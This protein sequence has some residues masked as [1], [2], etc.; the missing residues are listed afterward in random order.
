METLYSPILKEEKL[1]MKPLYR[2]VLLTILCGLLVACSSAPAEEVGELP[3]VAVLS[4]EDNVAE[5]AVTE[6]IDLS[7]SNQDLPT[8]EPIADEPET[9]D[10]VVIE[11]TPEP[12][13][14]VA[15][16]EDNAGDAATDVTTLDID[17]TDPVTIA[18]EFT[19]TVTDRNGG[20]SF[21]A[22]IPQAEG[23][24]TDG[25]MLTNGDV[26]V[27]LSVLGGTGGEAPLTIMNTAYSGSAEVQSTFSLDYTTTLIYVYDLNGLVMVFNTTGSEFFEPLIVE[28][29]GSTAAIQAAFGAIVEMT[30]SVELVPES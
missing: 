5:S 14:P 22:T 18:G 17:E 29:T 30:K 21:E 7:E 6:A 20:A 24:S 11:T 3:T 9:T 16:T 19:V 13:E 8:E 4:D 12:V 15:D 25:T 2:V 10:P 27:T 28:A 23:W 26:E 1:S